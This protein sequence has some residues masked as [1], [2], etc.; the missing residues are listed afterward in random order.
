MR[1]KRSRPRGSVPKGCARLPPAS[2]NGG[3]RRSGKE[4][5]TGEYG[6]KNSAKS[7]ENTITAMRPRGRMGTRFNAVRRQRPGRTAAASW[8]SSPGAIRV[9]IYS[10]YEDPDR[11]RGY[12]PAYSRQ[13]PGQPSVRPQ[14]VPQGNRET[15]SPDKSAGQY[16]A[17]QTPFR[18]ESRRSLK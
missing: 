6:V 11:H 14:L 12:R 9:L 4:I 8:T 18:R 2:Q 7:A 3:R 5:L 10:G 16:Q 15:R 1:V 13:S 17:R